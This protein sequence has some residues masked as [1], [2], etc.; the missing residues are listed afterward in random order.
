MSIRRRYPSRGLSPRVRGNLFT[1]EGE[2]GDPRSIP[3]CTGE[4]ARLSACRPYCEVYPRVYG[5]TAAAE[6]MDN[7]KAGL[8][9]R[10]RGNLSG[11]GHNGKLMRSIPACTGEPP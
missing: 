3:A 1:D 4:P 8:S 7:L 11:L 10:V 5:G 2:A 6:T 9:P